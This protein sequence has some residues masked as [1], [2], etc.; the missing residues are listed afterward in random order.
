[1]GDI[2]FYQVNGFKFVSSIFCMLVFVSACR[3]QSGVVT[4]QGGSPF[5]PEILNQSTPIISSTYIRNRSQNVVKVRSGN[6][7]RS[8]SPG[9][10]V[11]VKSSQ[12]PELN[13]WITSE[14]A[15]VPLCDNGKA[16]AKESC[17]T[18]GFN[19]YLEVLVL[20]KTHRLQA[21]DI[22]IVPEHCK[23]L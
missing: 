2:G 14:D 10:C 21:V 15:S 1:M 4:P 16:L 17:T 11:T 3:G 22:Q 5:Y 13:I 18:M 9:E 23:E 12:I 20:D 6:F 7:S 8:L 19:Q